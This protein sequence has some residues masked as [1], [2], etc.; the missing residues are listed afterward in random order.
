MKIGFTNGC[1][2]LFHPGHD[3]Y[4]RQ[5]A[6]QCDYLIVAVN[7]DRYCREVKGQGRPLWPWSRRMS[8]VRTIASAVI[9]FEGRWQ[10]LVLEI[11]PQVVF[12]GE[13]YRTAGVGG[14]RLAF[15]KLGWKSQSAPFDVIPIIY[16]PRLPGYS[17]SAEIERSGLQTDSLGT[18]TS[19]P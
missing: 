15:R 7:S 11:R 3:W 5:C 16:I 13:E 17:T 8:F 19:A 4:L 14:E 12:Q 18:H 1:F 9:P 2:D 10:P 6:K